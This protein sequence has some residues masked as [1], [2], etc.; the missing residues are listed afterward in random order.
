MFLVKVS[1]PH[2]DLSTQWEWLNIQTCACIFKIHNAFQMLTSQNMNDCIPKL[3]GR[4][5]NKACKVALN[6]KIL[7]VMSHIIAKKGG[8]YNQI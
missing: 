4:K 6:E 7:N 2:T 1:L 3:L 5:L 8:F